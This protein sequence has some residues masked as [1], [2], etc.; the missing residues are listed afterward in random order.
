LTS[1]KAYEA[2]IQC[3]REKASREF[4]TQERR[5]LKEKKVGDEVS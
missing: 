3:E 2:K 5:A 4:N 1:K